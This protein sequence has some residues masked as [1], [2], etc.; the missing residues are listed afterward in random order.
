MRW[1]S[2]D[3]NS[4]AVLKRKA[5]KQEQRNRQA[6]GNAVRLRR[7]QDFTARESRTTD[8]SQQTLVLANITLSDGAEQGT[9]RTGQLSFLESG[10]IG[11]L[12]LPFKNV[13][14]A[15]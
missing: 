2:T 10:V 5:G 13:C 6:K 14:F 9:L 15:F 12:P 4:N 1:H 3:S 7:V 11:G 8:I